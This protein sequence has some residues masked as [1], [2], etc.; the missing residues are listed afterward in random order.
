MTGGIN[1]ASTTAW[2]WWGCPA[3]MLEMVQAASCGESEEEKGGV[4]RRI[5]IVCAC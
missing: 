1:P 5:D 2:I 4:S 3:V